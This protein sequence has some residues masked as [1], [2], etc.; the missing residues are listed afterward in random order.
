V[1]AADTLVVELDGV[2]L[3]TPDRDRHR[4]FFEGAPPVCAVEY[5]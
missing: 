1:E 2:P 5:A 4:Q 3:F